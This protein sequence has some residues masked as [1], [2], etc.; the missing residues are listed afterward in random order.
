MR[1][2]KVIPLGDNR[3]V[4]IRELR[5]KDVRMLL[6]SMMDNLEAVTMRD[7]VTAKFPEVCRNLEDCV[8]PP[9]G[10]TL[11]DLSFSEI[12]V[13]IEGFKEVNQSFFNL[14]GPIN[15][16]QSLMPSISQPSSMPR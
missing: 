13:V 10:E 3:E 15:G 5:P 8:F 7:M 2:T 6:Q 14:L 9:S 11:E 1:N 12:E 4:I 16:L